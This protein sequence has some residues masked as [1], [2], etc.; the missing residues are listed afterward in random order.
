M[1]VDGAQATSILSLRMPKRPVQPTIPMAPV[2]MPPGGGPPGPTPPYPPQHPAR[3]PMQHPYAQYPYAPRPQVDPRYVGPA[4]AAP[5]PAPAYGA[6]APYPAHSGP[7]PHPGYSPRPASPPRA[8]KGRGALK[9]LLVVLGLLMLVPV[10]LFVLAALAIGNGIATTLPVL[11]QATASAPVPTATVAPITK[12]EVTKTIK[13]GTCTEAANERDEDTY[14]ALRDTGSALR[15][16]GKVAMLHVQLGGG[17]AAWPASITTR[18]DEAALLSQKFYLDQAKRFGVTDLKFDVI[19][20][21]LHSA[22]VQLP[23][24]TANSH[25]LLDP[26][27]EA[28]L[29]DEAEAGIETG[30]GSSL[31]SIIASYKQKGYDSVGFLIYLPA[32][33]D[34]RDFAWRATKSEGADQPEIAIL[35]PRK[36]QLDHLSVVAA[37]EGLHLFGADDLY[38]MKVEDKGDA[39]DLMGDY[40]TGFR[41]TTLDDTTAYAVGW[42]DKPPARRYAIADN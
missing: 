16:R 5:A 25:Q 34:A 2:A 38:R 21:P 14:L 33:T 22:Q 4:W 37:H 7:A 20:W 1:C 39:H 42:R 3:H 19:P 23:N 15:L 8:R 30:F 31:A 32:N 26:A 27:T 40:C 29:R 11:P 9:V 12:P 28:K 13:G 10:G 36:D 18:V 17:A 24:L 6:P 41:Q 35:F